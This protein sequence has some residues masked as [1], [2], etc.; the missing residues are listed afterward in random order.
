MKQFR[1]G[2]IKI[3]VATEAADMVRDLILF[4]SSSGS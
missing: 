2:K 1:E 4:F 3:L